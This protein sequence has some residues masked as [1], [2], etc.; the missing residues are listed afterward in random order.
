[1][2]HKLVVTIIIISLFLKSQASDS[3]INNTVDRKKL[4]WVAA[5]HTV[6]TGVSLIALNEAWYKGYER[7]SFHVRDDMRVWNQ[8]DKAGHAYGGYTLAGPIADAYRWAGV[9]RKTS[10]IIGAGGSVAFLSIIEM[11]DAHS[12]Q[13]GFS[14][15]DMGANVLGA[16]LFL[17]QEL[18]WEEQR[19]QLKYSYHPHRYD[20]Y[21]REW[22][23][24]IYGDNLPERML[25]DYNAQTYWLS[26]SVHS[27]GVEWWPSWLNVAIGYGGDNMY[28]AYYNSWK[29]ENGKYY[30]ANHIPRYR[31][32]FISPDINL[33]AIN[34]KSEFLNK[35]L[36]RLTIKIPAP[37]LELNARKKWVFYPMY[38]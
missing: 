1:M 23:N 33:A 18:A 3:T 15:G 26:V 14:Y 17:A 8:V 20:S 30:D 27:F 36:D 31:Q 5:S 35:V 32:L 6:F 22:T 21:F 25:K 16:G 10:A 12:A 9:N 2:P 29:D 24:D 38:F 34:T 4:L 7:T 13:W 19:I 28:G 11:L 37:A